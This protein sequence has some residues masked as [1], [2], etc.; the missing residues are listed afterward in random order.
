[1]C[2]ADCTSKVKCLFAKKLW[3]F[4]WVSICLGHAQDWLGTEQCGIGPPACFWSS[5][6]HL[7]GPRQSPQED[8]LSDRIPGDWVSV[9]A[10]LTTIK[11]LPDDLENLQPGC[12]FLLRW[13]G[14][15]YQ[16]QCGQHWWNRPQINDE[17]FCG[18]SMSH[19]LRGTCYIEH[20]TKFGSRIW[21]RSPFCKWEE[22]SLP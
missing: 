16:V 22:A 9:E 14:C 13:R 20:A 18:V 10:V 4:T 21:T 1:M 2:R 6:F 11:L 12:V 17:P 5:S 19:V 8:G 15:G 3:S 7:C